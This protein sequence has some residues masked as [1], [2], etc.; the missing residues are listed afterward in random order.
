MGIQWRPLDIPEDIAVYTARY[1]H[2]LNVSKDIHIYFLQSSKAFLW[3]FLCI[4][5]D[6]LVYFHGD[7]M[8]VHRYSRKYLDS[9]IIPLE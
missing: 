8:D 7:A 3:I 2:Y 5:V 4:P 6:I 9:Y 1:V